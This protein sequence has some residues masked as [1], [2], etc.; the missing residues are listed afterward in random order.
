[1]AQSRLHAVKLANELF[2][3]SS[4][5]RLLLSSNFTEF[6]EHTTGFRSSRP[7]PDPPEDALQLRR[8]SLEL[9]EAWSDR[10]GRDLPQVYLPY[11]E[12]THL[13]VAEGTMSFAGGQKPS[14]I[15]LLIFAR[16]AG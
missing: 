16:A 10:Y 7:L 1:M 6:L 9:L 2:T 4:T 12:V 8:V 5:F 3:R 15:K 11:E 13:I 14:A